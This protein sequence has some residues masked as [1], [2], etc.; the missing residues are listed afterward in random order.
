MA[1]RIPDDRMKYL[2]LLSEKYPT[3][4]SVT[5]EIINLTAILNLPKGTEHFM[6]DLHGEYEAFYHILN[7]CS[8]VIRE[9]VE[10]LYGDTLS[11]DEIKEICTLIYYPDRKLRLIRR[12]KH[13]D[14]DWYRTT[15]ERMLEIARVLSSK[16]TRSK[17]RKAMPEDYAY[18]ID[19]LLHAQRDED[20]NQVRYHNNILDSIININA[21]DFVISLAGLIKRLAVDRLHI[22]GDIYDRGD[23]ADKILDLL[24]TH[25]SLDIEWGNHDI[26]WM[27][28]ACGS[29]ACIAGAVRNCIN[30]RATRTL[31]SGYGISLRT[32]SGFARDTYPE[33]SP[34][35]AALHA[36]TVIQFKLEGQIILRNPEYRMEDRLLLDKIDRETG[37][38]TVGGKTYALNETS[39][40][41]VDP[42]DPYAL[43]EGEQA[44]MD[45][46]RASFLGSEKLRKH[47]AFLYDN[48]GMYRIYNGNLLYHGCVPMNDDGSF[49]EVEFFGEKFSGKAFFDMADTIA[50]HAYY[51]TSKNIKGLDFM[52]YLRCGANSP[53]CGRLTKGFERAFIDDKSAW[54]EPKN[55]YYSHYYDKETCEKI[56]K[57]FGLTSPASHI[58]NGH[59]PVR[60]VKGELPIRADGKL[61]VIDGGFCKNYHET[62]GIAGYTLIYNSH[63]LRLKAHR[64][65]RT[66]DEA[67]RENRDI[68][69]NSEIVETEHRRMMVG[70]TDVGEALHAQ[71]ADLYSLLEMYRSGVITPR[72]PE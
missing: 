11:H 26:L 25:H 16:Y 71:I 57:E 68:H 61:L 1:L 46:L 43:S 5:R 37:T 53:L 10:A 33:K 7:N 59:T 41:T 52:W 3:L 6:S 62:T 9:K 67:L 4:R 55:P 31:E 51:G 48:G 44:V 23:S 42:S 39:F 22:V 21:D 32:L 40:P 72:D 38:V 45:D 24:M 17:V 30:Y 54:S 65:F 60:T 47:T 56:L 29:D 27:G 58:V 64:P 2:R 28:A 66:I 18:I 12:E 13:I 50:R 19:E 15:L 63:G 14:R 8:G 69:S 34:E 20:N 36:I 35:K 49:R 70:D